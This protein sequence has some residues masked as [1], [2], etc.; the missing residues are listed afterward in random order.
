MTINIKIECLPE[1]CI[2][3]EDSFEFPEDI[4]T[5][6]KLAEITEWGWCTVCVIASIGDLEARECLGGCSFRSE[7]DFK[8][9]GYYADM[10][11]SATEQLKGKVAYII[12]TVK[13][14]KP[15]S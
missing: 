9:S 3:I 7:Q 2:S 14:L 11:Q 6:K 15:I 4:Q 1:N 12:D 10:V 13:E 5:V 8:D